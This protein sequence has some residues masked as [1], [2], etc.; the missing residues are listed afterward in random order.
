MFHHEDESALDAFL[1]EVTDVCICDFLVNAGESS[2]LF[3]NALIE[4]FYQMQVFDLGCA[5]MH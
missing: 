3:G 1:Q 4:H 2:V 5:D